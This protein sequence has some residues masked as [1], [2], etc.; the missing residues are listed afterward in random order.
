MLEM[1][2]AWGLSAS[3]AR[4]KTRSVMLSGWG[5]SLMVSRSALKLDDS[6]AAP[7]VHP[8]QGS[9]VACSVKEDA[10]A[11]EVPSLYRKAFDADAPSSWLVAPAA[12][13]LSSALAPFFRVLLWLT[14]VTHRVNVLI[15]WALC[16]KKKP[17][18]I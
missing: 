16:S 11:A 6:S 7:F 15:S 18:R 12:G 17:P 13:T 3:A 14:C 4:K 10:L 5:P 1:L 8:R 9:H 2:R